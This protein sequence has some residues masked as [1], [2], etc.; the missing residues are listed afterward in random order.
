M[1]NVKEVAICA[2]G[3]WPLP[4]GGLIGES[5]AA[6]ASRRIEQ[7]I[8]SLVLNPIQG[9]KVSVQH[10]VRQ[11][12]PNKHGGVTSFDRLT[13]EG[14]EAVRYDYLS[15]LVIDMK[16]AGM[17]VLYARARDIENGGSWAGLNAD[18]PTRWPR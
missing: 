10:H 4:N 3:E 16:L 14:Q 15:E 18:V 8:G 12:K 1:S 6:E 13:V 7:R 2:E 17:D 5:V 9:L 11:L